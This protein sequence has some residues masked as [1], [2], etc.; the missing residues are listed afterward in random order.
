MFR[1]G[2][3]SRVFLPQFYLLPVDDLTTR[4]ARARP[5]PSHDANALPSRSLVAHKRKGQSTPFVHQPSN[6]MLSTLSWV[7]SSETAQNDQPDTSDAKD[8][9][10]PKG[11]GKVSLD[12]SW[13]LVNDGGTEWKDVS[14]VRPCDEKDIQ[15]FQPVV[16]SILPVVPVAAGDDSAVSEPADPKSDALPRAERQQSAPLPTPPVQQHVLERIV[17]D[18][19]VERKTFPLCKLNPQRGR[20]RLRSM[21]R[22]LVMDFWAK[23]QRN[24]KHTH[25]VAYKH[26]N[27]NSGRGKKDRRRQTPRQARMSRNK[28]R[29]GRRGDTPVGD[30]YRRKNGHYTRKFAFMPA[31]YARSVAMDLP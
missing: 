5:I 13:V 22:R 26:K 15:E 30:V 27:K 10:S 11:D 21:P 23:E 4:E 24:A 20:R 17:H 12:P 9:A 28:A 18:R 8:V 1:C 29:S 31:N 25:S 3:P 16:E 19:P 7:W 14:L 6:A 2:A